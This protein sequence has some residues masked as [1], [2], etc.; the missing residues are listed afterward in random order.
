MKSWYFPIRR[1]EQGDDYGCA[2]ACVATVCGL[3][4]DRARYE[5]FDRKPVKDGPLIQIT[6]YDMLRVVRRLGFKARTS[7]R[8]VKTRHPTIVVFKWQPTV[9][10]SLCHSVVWD[11]FDRRFVDPGWDDGNI[12]NERYTSLWRDSG[13]RTLVIS[14]RRPDSRR[15]A[16]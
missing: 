7:S 11:P 5:F 8:L 6:V 1:V 16:A 10:T 13:T 15:L 3:T 12:T 4:Y 9:P 14:G 2:I